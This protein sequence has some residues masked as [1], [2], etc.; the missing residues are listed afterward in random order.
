[1]IAKPDIDLI[2]QFVAG[3]DPSER[4]VMAG[5]AL[6]VLALT[7]QTASKFQLTVVVFGAAFALIAVGFSL[8]VIG[9]DGAFQAVGARPDGT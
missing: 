4:G 6:N 2:G 8:F 1:A 9:A 5:Y 3:V 7:K